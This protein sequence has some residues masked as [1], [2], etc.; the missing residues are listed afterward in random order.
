MRV[1]QPPE[2]EIQGLPRWA[3][4]L[5]AIFAMA[6]V[7]SALANAQST[8]HEGRPATTAVPRPIWTTPG[9]VTPL[10]IRN[11]EGNSLY[12]G[13]QLDT[14]SC[15]VPQY[16][17]DTESQRLFVGTTVTCLEN[18][19]LPVLRR[20]GIV[21]GYLGAPG[22]VMVDV[23]RTDCTNE[24]VRPTDIAS[25][26]GGKIYWPTNDETR[27]H[28][29]SD[30]WNNEY[31]FMVLHEYSHH[32]QALSGILMQADLAATRV[33]QDSPEAMLISRR[34]ELQAQCLAGIALAAA[35]QGGAITSDDATWIIAAQS[36]MEEEPVHGTNV[37]NTRWIQIGYTERTTA[38]CN[39]WTALP[40]DVE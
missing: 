15:Q 29:Y 37:A 35:E 2:Y 36:D 21:S 25:Y 20:A 11:L 3:R 27:Q 30:E 22:L 8:E 40:S 10:V 9:I 28:L 6:V 13:L 38:A 4:W 32:I 23:D 18:A 14:V 26:C 12:A 39:T 31:F 16:D 34:L 7:V 33:R 1:Q 17:Q 5:L 19:W 24:I